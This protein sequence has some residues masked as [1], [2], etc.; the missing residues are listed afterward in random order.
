LQLFQGCLNKTWKLKI[1]FHFHLEAA[2]SLNLNTWSATVHSENCTTFTWPHSQKSSYRIYIMI[3]H[4]Y[5]HKSLH[6][7]IACIIWHNLIFTS[8][9]IVVILA[10]SA[11][12]LKTQ[13]CI[14]ADNG[15][16]W[17]ETTTGRC[18]C[19]TD[20]EIHACMNIPTLGL[21][22]W[23][24]YPKQ[25]VQ[26][27]EM[28]IHILSYS[29]N[30]LIPSEFVRVKV[31]IRISVKVRIRA[32]ISVRFRVNARVTFS[33]K[34][35]WLGS[36]WLQTLPCILYRCNICLNASS[37]EAYFVTLLLT[38]DCTQQV[39]TNLIHDFTAVTFSV[40]FYEI[41]AFSTFTF[42]YEGFH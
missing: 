26:Y 30:Q 24:Q 23:K 29:G 37:T 3:M 4:Y 9:Q 28:S 40:K 27:L 18:C 25:T 20:S 8:S 7:N 33:L 14:I 6:I 39:G 5:R 34:P 2:D 19:E 22:S 17:S 42:I 16:A 10:T 13:I 38:S 32:M 41:H 15:I 12:L 11:Q 36:S 35:S 21:R 31:R 1:N